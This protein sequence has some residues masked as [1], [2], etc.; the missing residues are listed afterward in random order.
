MGERRTRAQIIASSKE[1]FTRSAE[2]KDESDKLIAQG[3]VAGRPPFQLRSGS[4][5]YARP[6]G[7]RAAE[8]PGG[9]QQQEI[10]DPDEL[11]NSW[12]EIAAYLQHGVRTLQRWERELDLPVRR[13]HERRRSPVMAFKS[14]LYHWLSQ[15]RVSTLSSQIDEPLLQLPGL[16]R[17]LRQLEDE[18][19]IVRNKIEQIKNGV[20]AEE[21]INK[22]HTDREKSA[23]HLPQMSAD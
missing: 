2:L 17:R 11:L 1:L 6:Q 4:Y 15:T 18:M 23:V 22:G 5:D 21:R 13:P 20:P 16:E 8:I 7:A 3:V 14:E 12:K 19:E 10:K 9:A